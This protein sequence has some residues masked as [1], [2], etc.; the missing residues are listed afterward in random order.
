MYLNQGITVEF[1]Q[2]SGT[3]E[4]DKVVNWIA[5]TQAFVN[6]TIRRVDTKSKGK[7]YAIS[8]PLRTVQN[9]ALMN[10]MQETNNSRNLKFKALK[11]FIVRNELKAMFTAL[12]IKYVST[13]TY[14]KDKVMDGLASYINSRV[15]VLTYAD[16]KI[17]SKV[18]NIEIVSS[19]IRSIRSY[20]QRG[21]Y[22]SKNRINAKVYRMLQE[23]LRPVI[24]E[25]TMPPVMELR[26]TI[27]N[28]TAEITQSLQS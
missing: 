3:T 21:Q 13:Q 6:E 7:A 26:K 4:A 20:G 14:P 24:A 18:F 22:V 2:H 10:L 1:R 12:K 25:A 19:I 11:K 8:V 15:K 23:V 17:N 28:T 9:L 16:D 5:L 27:E